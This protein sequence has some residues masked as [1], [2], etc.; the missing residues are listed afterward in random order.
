MEDETA[1]LNALWADLLVGELISQGADYFCI[2]PGLR[3]SPLII[4]MSKHPL[5]RLFVHFDERALCFHALGFAKATGQVAVLTVTSGTAVGNLL[6][7]I[8][9]A[10]H[11][12]A[13]VLVLTADRPAELRHT[14]A[15]QTT[16]Q[17]KIFQNFVRWQADLPS[18]D[19]RISPS[20]I[21]ST[22]AHALSKAG[23]ANGGPV[24]L[25]CMFRE[26]LFEDT[27]PIASSKKSKTALLQ[28]DSFLS[29][30]QIQQ[31]S[32]ELLKHK[33]GI[34]IVGEFETHS[35]LTSLFRLSNL[36]KWPLFSDIL[37]P[38]RSHSQTE[39]MIPYYDLILKSLPIDESF[40][41]DAI[42]QFGNRFVSKK[43][44]D[45]ITFKKPKCHVQ[46]VSSTHFANLTHSVTHRLIANPWHVIEHLLDYLPCQ[47]P[48]SWF[49]DWQRLNGATQ[50]ALAQ[51]F[52]QEK[53][54]TG[55]SFFYHLPSWIPPKTP[56]FIGNSLPIRE[57]DSFFFPL[58][59]CGPLF[60]NRGLSG[61]DG[62]ISTAA[63]IS[64]GLQRPTFAIVGD[65][66]F[67]HDLTS[68]FHLKESPCPLKVIVINNDGGG[69]FSFFSVG[70]KTSFFHPFFSVPHGL[71]L[72]S[73]ADF[74]KIPYQKAPS[75]EEM[76]QFLKDQTSTLNII[77]MVTD[78]EENFYLHKQIIAHVKE[79]LKTTRLLQPY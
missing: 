61:I 69:I 67:L 60:G 43:L 72:K 24:H 49:S 76:E 19:R 73:G 79:S 5:A 9:E 33:K 53:A 14:D 62:N 8:M 23:G 4:A 22:I 54:L 2:S 7:G 45:W 47:L 32:D 46:T 78:K 48:S 42:L 39:G 58:K 16:D 40:L 68:F 56:L 44:L 75:L 57:A 38:I 11:S 31:V 30:E 36:L 6:P 20:F 10:H 50:K 63:G 71:K 74:L 77:E 59:N 34:I 27:Q 37:S 26:P 55:P 18:P 66:T 35:S 51:F 13:S 12:C 65:L 28:G 1:K 52:S 3:N 17:V 70:Q 21:G 25:N 64:R 15:N 41:P 29:K